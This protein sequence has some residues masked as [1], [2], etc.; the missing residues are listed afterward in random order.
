VPLYPE[1]SESL[2]LSESQLWTSA[3]CAIAGAFISRFFVG[4]VCQR[5]GPRIPFAALIVFSSIPTA[6]QGAVYTANQ[7]YI[8]RFFV[9]IG[10][11]SFVA[12][13]F[14]LNNMFKR[15]LAARVNGF[16]NGMGLAIALC[17]FF[18]RVVVNPLLRYASGSVEI[19]WRA[20]FS[21][22]SLGSLCVGLPLIF[23]TDD[24]PRGNYSKLK[25]T[26]DIRPMPHWNCFCVCMKDKNIWILAFQHACNLGI[27]LII[28]RVLYNYAKEQF[29]QNE[30]R[31]RLISLS[32][33]FCN[34]F[35]RVV[36]GAL[37]DKAY[38]Y[39]GKHFK[40][41]FL[42]FGPSFHSNYFTYTIYEGGK[43]VL[44]NYL[45]YLCLAG[46]FF[47]LFS[48]LSNIY[49]A[50][51]IL[52]LASFLTSYSQ[53]ATFGIV[54]YI[55]PEL[56]GVVS[57][58][59]G[60]AG[61]LGGIILGFVFREQSFK[62][63]FQTTGS[64][65]IIASFLTRFFF[66]PDYASLYFNEDCSEKDELKIVQSETNDTKSSSDD[67]SSYTMSPRA[68]NIDELDL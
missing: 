41:M 19:G 10:G 12:S 39:Y 32:F 45:V 27:E 26:G 35:G 28:N 49:V 61:A 11:G 64:L 34:Q 46:V 43:G 53:S 31:C 15:E 51:T 58:I 17:Y 63:A 52:F 16:S 21:I 36:G 4:F 66:I 65:F 37:I 9:G 33:S 50:L 20:S 57:G 23:L 59:I 7:F 42:Q 29:N 47:F 2:G 67:S 30:R 13:E 22:I 68:S 25:K 6:L 3:M 48:C 18:L 44:Q 62:H 60:S 24:T 8:V 1:I 14:W 56:N 40:W 5:Y 55:H 38:R 54:P